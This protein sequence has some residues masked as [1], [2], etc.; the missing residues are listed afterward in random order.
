[1]R[2]Y[3]FDLQGDQE[4]WQGTDLTESEIQEDMVQVSQ[5]FV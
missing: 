3:L 1:M 5:E 2:E 4:N